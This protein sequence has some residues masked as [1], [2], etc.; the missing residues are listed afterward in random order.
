MLKRLTILITLTLLM[1]SVATIQADSIDGDV[2]CGDLSD[3]DC[4][5]LLTN[6]EVMDGVYSLQ[7]SMA[8]AMKMGGDG[9]DDSIEMTG[10]GGGSL[11]VDPATADALE[12]A[13]AETAESDMAALLEMLLS[14]V[15]GDL[16]FRFDGLSGDEAIEMELN[17]LLKDGVIVIG[18]GAMEEMTGEEMTGLEWFG[19][20]TSGAIGVLLDEA[21]MGTAQDMGMSSQSSMEAVEDDATVIVRLPDQII[22]GSA[23]AVFE[24]SVDVNS[25]MQLLSLEDIQAAAGSGDGA[26]A[27]MARAMIQGMD[28]R[29][30]SSRHY[31]GLDDHYTRRME[32]A[33]DLTLSGELVGLEDGNISLI[34]N[35]GIDMTAFN[36]PVSVEIPE[37]AVVIPLAMMMQMGSQ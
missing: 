23:L 25:I 12:A 6:A 22:A 31:V 28:V 35:I 33:M 24:S 30:L 7:F 8:L 17:L 27:D 1:L 14:A 9:L 19:I 15:T 4:Q 5:I 11:A 32:M 13:A 37:D 18:A 10:T 3:A 21:G 29:E 36:Q 16:S 26:D 20:D 2:F 34:M